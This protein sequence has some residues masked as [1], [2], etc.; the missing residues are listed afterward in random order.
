MLSLIMNCPH[1]LM[2]Y[3]FWIDLSRLFVAFNDETCVF[4]LCTVYVLYYS[5]L[6]LTAHWIAME[7]HRFL[8]VEDHCHSFAGSIT[9]D[10]SWF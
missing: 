9:L 4:D 2:F 10:L 5:C 3:L 8:S 1:L 7:D 6:L